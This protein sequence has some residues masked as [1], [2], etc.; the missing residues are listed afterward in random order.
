MKQIG[1]RTATE[2]FEQLEII[3]TGIQDEKEPLDTAMEELQTISFKNGNGQMEDWKVVDVFEHRNRKYIVLIPVSEYEDETTNININLMRLDLTVQGG[4][5][6]CEV[7]TIPSDMEYE[8]VAG[9]FEK[10][11]NEANSTELF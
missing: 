4:I 11:V 5:E 1:V 3:D 8:D 10:R 6:G 7:T 9:I 2:A